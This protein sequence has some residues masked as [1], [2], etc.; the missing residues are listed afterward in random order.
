METIVSTTPDLNE[1]DSDFSR[2]T[3]GS[4]TERG[5]MN[6]VKELLVESIPWD[7]QGSTTP[8]IHLGID[9]Y[10]IYTTANTLNK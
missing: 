2:H 3:H 4:T 6:K 8:I 5:M 1:E 10:S 9:T 7:R